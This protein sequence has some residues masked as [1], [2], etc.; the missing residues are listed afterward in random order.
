M[1][2]REIG[3]EGEK[4]RRKGKRIWLAMGRNPT[5]IAARKKGKNLEGE[6]VLRYIEGLCWVCRYYYQGVCSWQWFYPY[7]YAPFASDIKGLPDLEITFFMGEPFKPFD[8]L[9][10]TLP[11][12][13]S[14]ALPDEYRKLMTDPRSPIHEFYPSDFEIDMNGKRFA[15]QGIAKL[16]FIDEKKLLAETKRLEDTLTAE[17]RIRNSV[18]FDLLYVH[19]SH[20]LAFQILLY[21][22]SVVWGPYQRYIWPLDACLSEGMNGF[23]WFCERNGLRDVVPSPLPGLPDL[24]YNQIL[25][26]TF[27]NPPSHAH[28]PEPPKGVCMPEKVLGPLDVKPFPLLWHEDNGG[29]R[30]QNREKPPVPGAISGLQ[31]GEA[32]HRLLKNTLNP[33]FNNHSGSSERSLYRNSP[34]NHFA[35]RLRTAGPSW[36]GKGSS[37]DQS[38]YNGNYHNARSMMDAPRGML[39]PHELRSNKQN[40]RAQDN[41]YLHQEQR[42]N[43][44]AAM[45]AL[46]V[47]DAGTKAPQMMTSQPPPPRMPN[48]GQFPNIQNQVMQ[49]IGLIPSPPSKWINKRGNGN[50]GM[51]YKQQQISSAAIYEKQVNLKKVYQVKSKDSLEPA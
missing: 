20:P 42:Q 21:Y 32:A 48:S 16:P 13:S 43:L 15:W 40:F 33:N 10:G 50:T 8:Q 30:Q 14:S 6:C 2:A 12:A 4:K 22:Q 11:A 37:E 24:E 17:E 41:R 18:M 49:N 47:E 45:S 3:R 31:L 19:P 1:A 7:H 25:N 51:H 5:G 36:Y 44:N 38:F 27:L 28:I 34:N 9:M 39:A 29:R 26:A 23:L 35:S 46:T